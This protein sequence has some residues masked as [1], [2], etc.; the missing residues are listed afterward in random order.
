VFW[1]EIVW[2]ILGFFYGE[3]KCEFLGF[4]FGKRAWKD[5]EAL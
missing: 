5:D 3:I 1:L 4:W 2:A